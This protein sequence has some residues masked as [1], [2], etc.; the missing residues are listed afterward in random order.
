M[1]KKNDGESFYLLVFV[2][3]DFELKIEFHN[4]PLSFV[5]CIE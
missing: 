4:V 3:N 2:L 5:E 1:R